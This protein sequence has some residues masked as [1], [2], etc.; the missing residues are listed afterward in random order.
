MVARYI[1]DPK[2][3]YKLELNKLQLV[4]LELQQVGEG[5]S[6]LPKVEWRQVELLRHFNFI[7]EEAIMTGQVLLGNSPLTN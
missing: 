5:V 7:I 3:I 4:F 2:E 1:T 6:E